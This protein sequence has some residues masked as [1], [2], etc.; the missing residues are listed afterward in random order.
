M[1][2]F[3]TQLPQELGTKGTSRPR[4]PQYGRP[5]PGTLGGVHNG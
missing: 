2:K 3:V 4:N 5:R 1:D